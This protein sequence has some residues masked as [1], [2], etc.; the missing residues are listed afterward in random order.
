M[1]S[2]NISSKRSLQQ[3]SPEICG[4]NLPK[5]PSS[6]DCG[7]KNLSKYSSSV[8]SELSQIGTPAKQLA[9]HQKQQQL[10]TSN[11]LPSQLSENLSVLHTHNES[12]QI[13]N[14]SSSI[15]QPNLVLLPNAPN[16]FWSTFDMKLNR[17]LDTK[18]GDVAKK[19]D[20]NAILVEMHNLKEENLQ[21]KQ[22]I[23]Q[24]KSRLELVEQVSKRANVVVSGLVSSSP[25]LANDE[26]TKL[27][28]NVLKQ[29]IKITS[30]RKIQAGKS[31]V[32]TLNSVLEA[33]NIVANRRCLKGTNIYIQKDATAEERTK[34]FHLR[35][36]ERSI[37]KVDTNIKI[38]QGLGR[39]YIADKPFFWNDGNYEALTAND[40]E[41]CKK[42]MNKANLNNNIII[43]Q[44]RSTS[45]SAKPTTNAV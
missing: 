5:R 19:D 42:L 33:E 15:S 1:S 34:M 30:S 6:V 37:R 18:L 12:R 25:N 17:I 9:S 44:Q 23:R 26:F 2:D 16:D 40:V 45:F 28:K 39:V 3:T 36:L 29:D 20:L 43:K 14:A 24:M 32:F 11:M 21:L 10:H 7:V 22:E 13:Q 35:F 27:C 38:R 8:D 31:Y 41:F 4:H